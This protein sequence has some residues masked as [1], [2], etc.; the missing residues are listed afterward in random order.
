MT[1]NSAVE[2][3]AEAAAVAKKALE[4]LEAE[5]R[6]AKRVASA[7]IEAR[8]G[9]QKADV[10][11][12]LHERNRDLRDAKNALPDHPWTGKKVFMECDSGPSYRRSRVRMDGVVEMRRVDTV[13]PEN[14]RWGIPEI[15]KPFVRL[16]KKDG[17]PGM[18]F[19]SI[20]GS[21]G[22]KWKLRDEALAGLPEETT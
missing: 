6:E 2:K 16:L 8:Y 4:A 12:T 14:V 7:E 22:K 20:H 9:N 13:F 3:A 5:I 18:R 1:D 17:T 11:A 19:E 10:M 15:G 21:W